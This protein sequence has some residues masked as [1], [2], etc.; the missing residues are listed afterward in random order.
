MLQALAVVAAFV[1]IDSV[2]GS[3]DPEAIPVMVG[4]ALLALLHPTREGLVRVGRPHV[5]MSGLAV[6]AAIPGVFF[7][8]DHIGLQRADIPS[9][10]HAEFAHWSA[11]AVF[12]TLVVLWGLIG[13]TELTGR[14]IT[15]WLTG[16]SAVTFGVASLVF[17]N[18]PSA[19]G[20]GW[21]VAAVAWG[22][23][24]LV[25]TEREAR[26]RSARQGVAVPR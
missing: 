15:A 14:R 5:G 3:F 10:P 6:L 25:L 18:L 4:V 19:A 17:P 1:V 24:Y 11:M 26:R 12:A 22:A 2:S 23:G 8:L 20:V 9:D 13:A 21:A 7:V 16:V